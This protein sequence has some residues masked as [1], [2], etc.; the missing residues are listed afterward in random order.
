MKRK[1]I[2]LD[3]DGVLQPIGSGKRFDYF[4]N[5]EEEKYGIPKLSERLESNFNIDYRKYHPYD[6]AAV[7]FDWNKDS[8][9]LLKLTLNLTGA[10]FV[11]SSDWRGNYDR[12]K[13]FFTIHGLEKYYIDDTKIRNSQI[14]KAFIEKVN[15]KYKEEKGEDSDLSYRTTE[16][17]EWLS[18]NPDVKKWVAID[19]LGLIG[20]DGHLVKTRKRYKWKD[21]EKAIR[22]LTDCF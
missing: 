9:G 7:V 15:A 17:L 21:A 6:V 19:D 14:D 2:F 5:E 16:I 10:M 3:I 20:L 11:L 8:V 12:M 22:I 4:R 18:R 1:I 13:D